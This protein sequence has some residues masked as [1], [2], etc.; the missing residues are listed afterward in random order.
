MTAPHLIGC[1]VDWLKRLLYERD[2]ARG[3]RGKRSVT[4]L[5]LG[6]A[7]VFFFFLG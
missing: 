1:R 2:L 5:P 4:Q 3:Y 7:L 6:L